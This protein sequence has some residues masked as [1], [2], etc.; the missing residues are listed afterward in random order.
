[1]LSGRLITGKE[2]ER[3]KLRK[4]EVMKKLEEWIKQELICISIFNRN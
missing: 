4:V 3:R 1:M 2:Q